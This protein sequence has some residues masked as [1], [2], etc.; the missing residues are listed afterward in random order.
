MFPR[1]DDAFFAKILKETSGTS[2]HLLHGAPLKVHPDDTA[3][4]WRSSA[5]QVQF[6][7]PENEFLKRI[8]EG[9]YEPQGYYAYLNPAGMKNWRSY[10]FGDK[11]QKLAKI[12]GKYDPK[13]VFGKPLTIESLGE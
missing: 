11:W 8:V 3:Y 2:S 13:D 7:R 10:F 1:F 4:P 12:R 5:L 6:Y 9:G